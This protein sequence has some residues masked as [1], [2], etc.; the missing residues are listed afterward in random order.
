MTDDREVRHDLRGSARVNPTVAAL[1]RRGFDSQTANDIRALRLTLAD[2][3]QRDDPALEQLGLSASQI[4]AVREG[5][6][7][8]IPFDTLVQVLWANRSSCCVCRNFDRAIILHHIVPWSRSLDHDAANLAVLCLEHHARA[9]RTGTLEQ[10][11]GAA[12]LRAFKQKWEEEVRHLDPKAILDAT[13]VDGHHWWWFNHVRILEMAQRLGIDLTRRVNFVS[14]AARGWVDGRGQISERHLQSPYMY[15]GG[16][17]I[18]LYDYMREVAEEVWARTTIFNLS[19]DLDPGF[20]R[21]VV[22]PGDLI[23]VQGRHS[24]KSLNR[25]VSG[26]GQA[27]A[28]QRQANRV[29]ITFTIDRW[30]AVAN[31]SWSAWLYGTQHAA[32]ILRVVHIEPG[33]QLHLQCTGIAIG[34]ALQGLSTRHYYSATWPSSVDEEVEEGGEA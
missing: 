2:L 16:D 32:S 12:Q 13:R 4:A 23:L 8:P 15:V 3:K 30:E 7:P 6:R 27:C 5:G 29:R 22:Q 11:L 34:S 24:F 25:E 26:P 14:V 33:E 10:N 28:V 19:D 1:M 20:L 9:H 31:S 18:I 21:R 17:G